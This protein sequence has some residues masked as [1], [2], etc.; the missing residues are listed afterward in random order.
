MTSTLDL[1]YQECC[2][3]DLLLKDEELSEISV[4]ELNSPPPCSAAFGHS[5]GKVCIPANIGPFV[6][7]DVAEAMRKH[8]V[9]RNT[10]DT[11]WNRS[12]RLVCN[13]SQ[14]NSLSESVHSGSETPSPPPLGKPNRRS[15]GA[16]QMIRSARAQAAS[17]NCS[18]QLPDLAVKRMSE[19]TPATK[20]DHSPMTSYCPS[21]QDSDVESVPSRTRSFCLS[22]PEHKHSPM[23]PSGSPLLHRPPGSARLERPTKFTK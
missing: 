4:L 8:G 19:M 7:T 2:T 10:D 15:P 20:I 13:T 12:K 17:K 21:P 6:S 18:W 22:A 14:A 23:R 11:S 16:Q 3:S 1:L 5:S 9:I